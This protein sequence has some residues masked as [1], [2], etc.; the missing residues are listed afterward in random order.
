MPIFA[1]I[2]YADGFDLPTMLFLRFALAGGLMAI[3]MHMRGMRW[4]RGRNLILLVA[5]GAIGYSGQ[6]YCYF[7][8]LQYATAGLTALLLYLY[9]VIVTLV[10]A[11]LS[12]KGL[13]RRRLIAVLAALAGT[14]MAVGG[15]L[16]GSPLG[17]ALGVGA[18]LIYSL[19]ILVGERVMQAEGAV[20]AGT[21]VMLSSATVYACSLAFIGAS[22]PRTEAG[23]FAMGGIA[24]LS[25]LLAIIGFF[26]AMRYL[27]A[28]DAATFST[29]EP[30]V[31]VLLAAAFLGEGVGTWQAVG[32]VIILASVIV[33]ARSGHRGAATENPPG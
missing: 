17:I 27:G 10:S 5:M 30:V 23:W 16:D 31:T 29:M 7:A 22:W 32:G 11:A 2:A 15:S 1:K 20:A 26:I 12:G 6:A 24:L 28:A 33:L 25:T 13:S 3:V 9:P 18:A 8:A 19:Y 21:V 14:G 4:P